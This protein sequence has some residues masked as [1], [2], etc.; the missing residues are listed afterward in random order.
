MKKSLLYLFLFLFSFHTTFAQ[1]DTDHWFAPYFDS[2]S[3][4]PTNYTHGLYFSTDSV[5]PF[6]IKIYSNNTVIGTVTISKSNPQTFMLGAQYIRTTSSS[7]A[8]VPTNLGVYT[9]GDKP[10]FATLRIYNISH[11]EIITSKGKAGIGTQFY[12]AAT[13][14]TVSSISNNFTTGIMATE[15]N[16]TVTIS[17]YDPNIQFINNTS[18]P[19]SLTTTLNKGQSYILAGL[20]NTVPNQTGFIG[21][22]IVS[23]KPVSVTNGNSNGFYATAAYADGSD[24]IM[25]QSVPL[26]RLGNEFAMVKSISTSGDNMEGGIIIATE[27]NTEI[28]L[29][30]GTTPVATINEGDYY[31][32]MANAYATQAGGHSNIYI[33]TTK[34]V[35]LYQLIG[36]GSANNTGGYNYIPPL[37]CFLPRKIDEI[38]KIHEMPSYNGNVNLKLNI[39]TE[40]GAAVTVNGMAPTAAQG[41]FPL[42]GNTQWVTYAIQGITGNV[43]ITSTKAVTAGINGGYSTA[44]YGGYFAGFSSIPVIA[45]QTGD[46]I[47]GIILEVDDSFETYQWSLNG[48]PI[49]GATSNSYTPTQAGNYT[50]R[51]TVGSC[52]PAITPVYKVFSCLEQSTKTM[53]ICEGYQAI[54]PEFTNSTQIYVPGTVTI[55]TPPANG[56]ATID[57]VTGVITYIPNFGYFGPDTIVYKFCGNAPEFIDCEQVSLNLTVSATPVV[58]NATLRTCFLEQNP[59]TGLFNL[60]AA[61]VTSQTGVTKKYYPSPTDAVNGTN[62]IINPIAYIA[63]N[64]VVYIKVTNAN[65]CYKVVEVTLIVLAPIK[66]TVLVDKIICMEDKTTLDAGPGFNS[67]EWSTGASTQT[68]TNVG[69]GTYWVKLKTGECVTTQTVNVYASEQPVISNID[70]TSNTVTVYANGGTPPYKYSIDN[71]NWQDSNVFSDIPRGD[72]TV[73]IKDTYNCLPISVSITIPNLVNVITP[74]DDGINDII[75]Y[76]SLSYKPNMTFNIYDRYGAKIHQGDKSNGYKWNGTTNGSKRVSTGNYWFDISWN[77]SNKRQTPIK[78]SGWILVKNRE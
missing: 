33:R 24:L 40:A 7:S 70:I 42:T 68:I 31:R 50:V 34:N 39:L 59:T 26:E 8:L 16:T 58:N 35:Y 25:D 11:G 13:P 32:I 4:S 74:N 12:A 52:P 1:R 55:V 2:S 47:P 57:P 44:G 62:E 48:N 18:P 41:P 53:T 6:E 21:A 78:F 72:I 28:Y 75:D 64:G 29:N 45:K 3:S 73:Y 10:Y 30:A 65:G 17:G 22:K 69:V 15:D 49:P 54:V 46:C 77:E 5:T 9:K 51:I 38:G 43:T 71:I 60:T 36:A 63:P 37:N 20:G 61:A 19:L 66:S 67:Y 23:D 27:N 76:S 14:M 56:T